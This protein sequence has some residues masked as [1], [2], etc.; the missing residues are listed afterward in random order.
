MDAPTEQ[1]TGELYLFGLPKTTARVTVARHAPGD[2][3]TRAARALAALWGVAALAIL[4]PIAHFV[5]VPGFFVAG[6]VVGLRKLNELATVTQV[7]GICPRCGAERAFEAGGRLR[8]SSKASCPACHN[9][10][11]L[12][13]DPVFVR[14]A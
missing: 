9:Q 12:T 14:G 4:V 2:R 7:S 5:L 3:A 1:L 8:A 11:D 6:I 10:L 13:I